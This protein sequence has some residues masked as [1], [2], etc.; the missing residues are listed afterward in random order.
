LRP[1]ISTIPDVEEIKF[2]RNIVDAKDLNIESKEYIP[3]EN[4]RYRLSKIRTLEVDG[5]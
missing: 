3:I 2:Q 4:L 1:T 5:G